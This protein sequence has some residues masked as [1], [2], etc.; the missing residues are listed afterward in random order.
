VESIAELHTE[1]WRAAYAGIMPA[2]Y[3]DG[4]LFAI[5]LELWQARIDSEQYLNGGPPSCLLVAEGGD[6]AITAFAYLTPQR[7]ERIL[8][9]N[10]HVRPGSKRSGIGRRLMARG[11]GWAAEHHPDQP[12]YLDVLRDNTPARAFYERMGGSTSRA[13]VEHFHAGFDLDML[14]YT[15]SSAAV[16]EFSEICRGTPRAQAAQHT[17]KKVRDA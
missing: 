11:L 16:Q 5:N 10:L 17:I 6:R 12:V 4:P 13:Y 2:G 8:L 14:E 3:L 7:D 1:S 15:W 9:D